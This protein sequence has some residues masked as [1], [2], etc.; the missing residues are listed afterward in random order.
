MSPNLALIAWLALLLTL[1]KFDPATE[2]RFSPALWI[3]VI[4]IAIIGSRLP[5]Q[6]LGGGIGYTS[7]GLSD[8]NSLDRTVYLILIGLSLAVLASRSFQWQVFL[9]RNVWLG[10]MIA[11]GL[12][13][14]T[15][16]DFPF[17]AFKRWFRDLGIYFAILVILSSPEPMDSVRWVL[18]RVFYLLIP[19]SVVLIKYFPHL[20]RVFDSWTGQ[21][22]AVGV[23]TSKNML[24]VL[25]MVSALFFAWDTIVRW[26]ERR[27]PRQRSVL[28]VNATF[29]GMS[30]WLLSLAK[31][32]TSTVC[33]LFGALVLV[34]AS[35]QPLR[36]R[37]KVLAV[38]I[39][40]GVMLYGFLEFVLGIDLIG[41]V[42]QAAGRSPDLTGRSEIWSVLLNAG[43]NP[44]IGTGY[45]SFWLGS[46]LE[47]IWTHTVKVN[48]AHNGYLEVYL[49]L[50]IVGLSLL[51]GF[52]FSGYLRIAQR[53]I[54][55]PLLGSFGLAIWAILLFYNVT[56]SAFRLQILW[57]VFLTLAI[58]LADSVPRTKRLRPGNST[59]GSRRRSPMSYSGGRPSAPQ[60][61]SPGDPTLS[62]QPD[63]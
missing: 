40:V 50:G 53:Y 45:E 17:I 12:L 25:C 4:W 38:L 3:P 18:R 62:R 10:L 34:L 46:R 56:E 55:D 16:S 15:W 41:L 44:I 14:I 26:P 39:P 5:A 37:P 27:Q 60:R 43:A 42:A 51:L 22:Y 24:G 7:T 63:R 47:W 48:T 33:L 29:I 20:A 11:F 54:R 35:T 9:R 21:G 28:L 61:R 57:V 8:G 1:L 19:L 52:L 6:W 23:T 2:R 31:S 59:F 32:A 58:T 30:L 13:S 36:N 49:S